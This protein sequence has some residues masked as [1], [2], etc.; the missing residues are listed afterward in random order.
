MS[1]PFVSVIIPVYNDADRLAKCLEALRVQTY[2]TDRYE[3]IVVDNASTE[4]IHRLCHRFP[5]VRYVHEAQTGSYAARNRGLSFAQGEIIAFTDADCIPSA[6]WLWAGVSALCAQ[7]A[8][9]VAGHIQFFFQAPHPTVIEYIDALSHLR[10]Q[11]Y[12]Q[13]GY[14]ATANLFT[15]ARVFD[16]VGQFDPHLLSLGDRQWGQ[17]VSAAGYAVVYCRDAWVYHPARTTLKALIAKVRLQAR[18]QRLIEPWSTWGIIRQ[19]RPLGWRFW[20]T[21]WQDD[22]LRGWDK[23]VF[24]AIVQGLKWAIGWEMAIAQIQAGH[25]SNKLAHFPEVIPPQKSIDLKN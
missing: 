9:I 17:R 24:G 2:A 21:V 14:G 18:H 25:E 3:V 13:Q 23:W 8:G 22:T 5:Q 11:D 1:Q 10:Q 12:A 15:W 16:Q 6:G 19:L 4:D 7:K 20:Q